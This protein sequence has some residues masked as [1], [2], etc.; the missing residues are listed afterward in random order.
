M[1]SYEERLRAVKLYWKLG[2][3]CKAT[4]HQLGYPTKN[5]LKGWHDEFEKRS[6]LQAGSARSKPKYSDELDSYEETLTN[7]CSASL[8][9]TVSSGAP[10]SGCTGIS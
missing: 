8:G 1:Y 6:D 4:I 3:R 9:D 7:Y 5:T 10:P 2:K